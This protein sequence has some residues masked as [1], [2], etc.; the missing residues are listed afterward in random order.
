MSGFHPKITRH[1]RNQ[2]KPTHGE[3]TKQTTKPDSE[4]RELLELSDREFKTN[5]VN[6]SKAV[7]EMADNMHDHMVNYK[8][9]EH[10]GNARNAIHINT[11]KECF[12]WSH[13]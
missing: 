12:Q 10:N 13:Q 8:K 2:K 4:M 9:K 3:E 5:L 11:G 1:T 7:V 6:K